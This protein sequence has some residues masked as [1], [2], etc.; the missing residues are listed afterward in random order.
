[1]RVEMS[2][3]STILE[4]V[5]KVQLE[6]FGTAISN[7]VLLSNDLF[8]GGRVPIVIREPYNNEINELIGYI[9]DDKMSINAASKKQIYLAVL[10]KKV[11]PQ[12]IKSQRRDVPI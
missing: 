6:R 11:L 3:R 2:R 9:V 7:A 1:M 12:Y 5:E 10:T 8:P 4:R